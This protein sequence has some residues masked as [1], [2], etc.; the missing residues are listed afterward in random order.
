[1]TCHLNKHA[2]V[3][4]GN[5]ITNEV[6]GLADVLAVQGRVRATQPAGELAIA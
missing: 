6:G 3:I 1:M 4:N 5:V 2:H